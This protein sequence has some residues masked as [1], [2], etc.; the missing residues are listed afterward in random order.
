MW[1][2]KKNLEI[3]WS[4]FNAFLYFGPEETSVER[5][6]YSTSRKSEEMLG[7]VGVSSHCQGKM[8]HNGGLMLLDCTQ[9][10]SHCS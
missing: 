6:F 3:T 2:R 1:H 7:I 10:L 5:G 9:S 4:E 8:E